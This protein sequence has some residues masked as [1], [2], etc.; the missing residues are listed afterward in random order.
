MEIEKNTIITILNIIIEVFKMTVYVII[1]FFLFPLQRAIIFSY[2]RVNWTN[3]DTI[4]YLSLMWIFIW[5]ILSNFWRIN[6]N[7][8]FEEPTVIEEEIKSQ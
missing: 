2:Y 1:E 7:L 4:I 5:I 6:L 3:M 8:K